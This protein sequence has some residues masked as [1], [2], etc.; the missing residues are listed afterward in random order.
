MNTDTIN[1]DS[2]LFAH[3]SGNQEADHYQLKADVRELHEQLAQA[4]ARIASLQ[5]DVSSYKALARCNREEA[6]ALRCAAGVSCDDT[7]GE[8]IEK[9]KALAARQ[10]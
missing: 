10:K 9:V 3:L 8:G 7:V 5:T 2:K 6:D 4:Q 1:K